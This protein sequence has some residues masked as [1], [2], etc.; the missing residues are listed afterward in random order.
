MTMSY[1][2]MTEDEEPTQIG[3]SQGWPDFCDWAISLGEEDYPELYV[4]CADGDTY[5]PADVI[6]DLEKAITDKEPMQDI[7]DTANGVLEFC[8]ANR[9]AEMIMVVT[10]VTAE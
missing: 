8:R 1:Q 6:L 4:F 9:T 3:S 2:I 7:L 5:S 10:G